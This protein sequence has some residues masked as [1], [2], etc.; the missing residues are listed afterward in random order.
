MNLL[1]RC[2]HLILITL[3]MLSTV[4]CITTRTGPLPEPG[5]SSERLQ[6][7][8]DL[9]RGYLSSGE[10]SRAREPLNRALE[11]DRTSIDALLLMA[12]L[13]NN[14]GEPGLAEKSYLRALRIEP[15]NA[16]AL[17]NYG[18][19]LLNYGRYEDALKPLRKA[20]ED[21]EYYLRSQSYEYLGLAEKAA[22]NNA[23]AKA[24]FQR[25]V[26]LNREQARSA[27]ELAEYEL[28]EGKVPE[29]QELY[30]QFRRY[31]KQNAR[32]LCFGIQLAQAGANEDSLASYRL[33]LKNLFPNSREAH[34]CEATES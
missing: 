13:H 34:R 20:V 3:V 19:F 17:T 6:A 9:A 33:A 5:S 25:A 1:R 10:F 18:S 7:Q 14:E 4:G 12:V 21:P 32:S 22:G 26:G 23:A 24:A 30:D 27:L 16:Q 31:A 15:K 11:L 8:L 29:A 2:S 28:L